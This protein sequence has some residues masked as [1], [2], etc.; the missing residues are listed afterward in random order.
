[1]KDSY[2]Y[3][4]IAV[5]CLFCFSEYRCV[6]CCCFLR[7]CCLFRL[8]R[9][10]S[11]G[12]RNGNLAGASFAGWKGATA[13]TR[14][15]KIE[16]LIYVSCLLEWLPFSF[17]SFSSRA[18]MSSLVKRLYF[19]SLVTQKGKETKKKKNK[20]RCLC[21]CFGESWTRKQPKR[22]LSLR[23]PSPYLRSVYRVL[24][25]RAQT[26]I[27]DNYVNRREIRRERCRNQRVPRNSVYMC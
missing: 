8:F 14:T 26:R 12:K 5:V 20:H 24:G 15:S 11:V 23:D 7:C 6:G 4:S 27:K 19:I 21:T 2:F 3:F 18:R 9:L 17:L 22:D 10:E 13:R 25:E 16:A 1:M